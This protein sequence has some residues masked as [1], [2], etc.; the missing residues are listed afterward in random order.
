MKKV[1]CVTQMNISRKFLS[2]SVFKVR[3]F[4]IYFALTSNPIDLYKVVATCHY[5]DNMEYYPVLL[6]IICPFIQDSYDGAS[7]LL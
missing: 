2:T 7:Y 5:N 3:I 1:K 4:K 6:H